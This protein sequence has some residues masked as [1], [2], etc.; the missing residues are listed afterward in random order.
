MHIFSLFLKIVGMLRI[1]LSNALCTKNIPIDTY[2]MYC[3]T[4]VL[5]CITQKYVGNS[6]MTGSAVKFSEVGG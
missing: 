2:Y 1:E 6:L 3:G 4:H 5:Q